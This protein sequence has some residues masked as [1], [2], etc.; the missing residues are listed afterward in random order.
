MKTFRELCKLD[1]SY[2]SNGKVNIT[3]AKFDVI[4]FLAKIDSKIV[5]IRKEGSLT[6]KSGNFNK[7]SDIIEDTR[8]FLNTTLKEIGNK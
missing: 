8:N 2:D 4:W 3:E 7:F 1:E 6:I 5:E